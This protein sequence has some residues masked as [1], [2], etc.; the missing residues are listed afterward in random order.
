MSTAPPVR[1][2]SPD[3]ALEAEFLPG[4]G[5]VGSSLR[6][7]GEE[8]LGQRG[9]P[10]AYAQRKS[11]FGIPLLYPWANRLS[12]WEYD[13]GRHVDLDRSSTV[14]K[15]DPDTGLPIHGALAATPYWELGG[16]GSGGCEGVEATLDYAAHPE[17]MSVFPFAHRLGFRASV[18][19]E[20]LT[21]RLDVTATGQDRVPISFGF[22]PYLTLPG[23]RRE[24]WELGLPVRRQAVLDDHGIPSGEHV[25]LRPGALSGVL[26]VRTF[27]DSFDEL[28]GEPPVFSLADARRRIALRYD[29]GYPFAQVYAPEGSSFIAFEPMTAAVNALR[30]GGGLRLLEPAQT[31]TAR[32]TISVSWR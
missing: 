9:G 13:Q 18:N 14:L 7:H 5:M 26:G 8:L 4:L 20:E 11:T 30:T 29:E 3:G 28:S 23:A 19:D 31:F 15:A 32:F 16:V 22:H 2:R 12:D 1:L 25:E 24:D 27:D 10:E 6:H 21:V 17:L